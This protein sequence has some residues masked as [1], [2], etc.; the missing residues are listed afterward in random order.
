MYAILCGNP[1]DGFSI[2]GPL[3]SIDEAHNWAQIN[4]SDEPYCIAP[5]KSPKKPP[6]YTVRLVDT[7]GAE[8]ASQGPYDT[9]EEALDAQEKVPGIDTEIYKCERI[10]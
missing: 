9:L 8:L 1:L 7:D 2:H 3:D 6:Y 10:K 5:L 4:C